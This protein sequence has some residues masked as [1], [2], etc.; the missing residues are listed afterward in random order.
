MLS[1]MARY[2][3]LIAEQYSIV[4]IHRMFFMHSSISGH[5]DYFHK[6]A[7]VNNATVNIGVHISFQISIFL[8]SG[9]CLEVNLQV[10]WQF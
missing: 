10:I 5:L 1:Q 9:K 3:F 7:V 8:T 2:I 4:Y 6:L